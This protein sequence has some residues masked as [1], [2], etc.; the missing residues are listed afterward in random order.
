MC[1]KPWMFLVE[2]G[3]VGF[4]PFLKISIVLEAG[5]SLEFAHSPDDVNQH[6]V[7]VAMDNALRLLV[8]VLVKVSHPLM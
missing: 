8:D 3:L 4:K 7:H 5:D 1:E 6:T 2:D